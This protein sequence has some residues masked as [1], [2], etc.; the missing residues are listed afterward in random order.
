MRQGMAYLSV[1]GDAVARRKPMNTNA[2]MTA[3][4]LEAAGQPLTLATV[5]RPVAGAGQVLVR[6]AAAGLNPLD[7]K[8][9]AGQGA[10]ARQPAPAILGIDM[11][12]HVDAVG[13]GVEGFQP[14]DAVYGMTGGVGGVQGS[15]AQYAAVDA[16]LLA[17]A[18]ASMPLAEAAVLPLVFITAWEGLVDRANVH[19]GQSVLVIAGAGGVGSMA[20][21]LAAARGARVFATGGREQK[22][23]IEG[24]GA[25][26][27]DRDMPINDVVDRHTSGE[28][29][30]IVYDTLGGATL[31]AAFVAARRYGGHVVSSLGWGTHAL[32]P[33][34]FRAATYSG[35]FTLMPL[36]T[37]RGR[38]HHG[39]IMAE[40]A[41]LADAGKLRPV[42][43]SQRFTLAEG[44][45]ALDLVESGKAGGKVVVVVG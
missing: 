38:E 40:A 36:L 2:T 6:I 29:F 45:A 3:L 8:I 33:L 20:V 42:L 31:D 16:R 37:G 5:A 11:A 12:G 23:I 34:S 18:P 30:D 21:Q 24:L 32:A 10:H 43:S 17:H 15:L 27:V 39:Q 7:G 26:W 4:R 44:N 41:K 22:D 9:R 1:I 25:T 13:D 19:G 35:V 14:G 28:G